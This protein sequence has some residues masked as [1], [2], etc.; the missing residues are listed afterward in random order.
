MLDPPPPPHPNSGQRGAAAHKYA[1]SGAR[2]AHCAG[3]APE[4]CDGRGAEAGGAPGGADRMRG[5]AKG[6][7]RGAKGG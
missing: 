7:G 5:R 1:A 3:P 2:G 6:R 4:G